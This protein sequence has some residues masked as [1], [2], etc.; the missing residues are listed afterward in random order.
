VASHTAGRHA[1]AGYDLIVLGAG[2]AGSTIAM[3]AVERGASVALLEPSKVVKSA[4]IL[5]L[6][7]HADRFGLDPIDPAIPW[8]TVMRRVAAVID[9]IR[10]GDGDRNLR[11]KG[12][13][14]FKQPG[15]FVDARMVRIGEGETITGTN[16][17]IATGAQNDVPPIEGLKET[18]FIDN[19]DAVQ[20]PELPGSLAI[21]GGGVIAAEFAQIFARFG[22]RVTVL[23]RNP[24]LLPKE[25]PELAAA[26]EDV[27]RAEGIDLH[28]GAEITRVEQHGS[29]KRI[30]G[31]GIDVTADEIM[32]AA[33]RSP[34]VASLNLEAAGVAY[35]DE[36]IDV[37][38]TMQTSV[39]T[40]WA[41][42]DVTG[43]FPFTH[44]ADYQARIVLHNLFERGPIEEADYRAIPWVTFTDPELARVGKTEAEA[45]KEGSD[46]IT[47]ETDMANLTRAQVS[48]E[49]AGRV[50]LVVD[51]QTREI[52]GGHV[53]AAHGGEILG[54]IVLAM[55]H[56]LPVEAI[57]ESVHA[58]PTLSEA[59][60]WTAFEFTK[61]DS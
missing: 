15:R 43:R 56:G 28:L 33:G 42:G 29:A 48:N 41:C 7:R 4:Q 19:A 8:A 34:D 9:E 27:L 31:H 37:S 32:V 3:E 52:V 1:S 11:D 54:E 6:M 49:R 26:L 57:A 61:G 5:H 24:S 58:Y 46:V 40:I 22:V 51:R 18:G 17:V 12:I 10:G 16:I 47:A 55:R 50:K 25:E 23:G 39:P 36:G 59:V 21:V 44:V 38:A 14:L 13:A 35:S 30:I 45:R 2:S 53:L 20:L 60:F